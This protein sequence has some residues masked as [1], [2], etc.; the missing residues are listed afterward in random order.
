MAMLP[1]A[2]LLWKE[3]RGVLSSVTVRFQAVLPRVAAEYLK[4]S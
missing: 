3:S 1:S 4:C 2:A